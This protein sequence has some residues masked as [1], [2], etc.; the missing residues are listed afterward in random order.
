MGRQDELA[1]HGIVVHGVEVDQ[2]LLM[3]MKL[4]IVAPLGSPTVV[5]VVVR[6]VGLL[7]II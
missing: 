5:D 2:A 6:L 7:V 4:S 1:V 3:F